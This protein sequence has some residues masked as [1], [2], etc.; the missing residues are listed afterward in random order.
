MAITEQERR[1]QR[2]QTDIILFFII[3]LL[4]AYYTVHMGAVAS[5]YADFNVITQLDP[6]FEE[7]TN[8]IR[9]HPIY[10]PTKATLAPFYLFTLFYLVAFTWYLSSRKKL[11]PGKE[12]G[13]AAWAKKMISAVS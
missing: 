7:V 13:T 4:G 9:D 3:Y 5:A 1:R 8:H 12:H 11:L 10:L 2:K 6:F